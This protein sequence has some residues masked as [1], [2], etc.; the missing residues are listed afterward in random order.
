ML[1]TVTVAKAEGLL[2]VSMHSHSA[3]HYLYGKI[4]M[5]TSVEKT[6]PKLSTKKDA[7]GRYPIQWAASS[8]N[9]DIVTLLANQAN[10]DPDVQVCIQL[11]GWVILTIQA[12]NIIVL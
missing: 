10:F 8:N 3:F 7:D 2:N 4:V 1:T 9:L 5:L 12:A 11:V 6:D